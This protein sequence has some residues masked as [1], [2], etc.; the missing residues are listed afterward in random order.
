MTNEGHLRPELHFSPH[1]GWLNDP[2]GLIF[3]NGTWHLY[4]QHYPFDTV[5]GPM[6]WGH[7]VSR[8]LVHWEELSIALYPEGKLYRF[9][10]SMVYD[11]D[12]TSGMGRTAP[13]GSMIPPFAAF[14]TRHIETGHL[15]SQGVAFSYDGGV[16]FEDYPGN[17]VIVTP[18]AE[19][20]PLS[21]FRDPKVF[22]NPDTGLWNMTVAAKYRSNFYESRDLLH[23]T[24]TGSFAHGFREITNVWA[25]TDLIPFE[26]EEGRKWVL[27]A[28]MENKEGQ[29]EPRTMYFVGRF[30]GG[31]FTAEEKTEEPLWI[32]F[33]WDN[34]AGVT[35]NDC[36]FP[37]PVM[38][39]WAVNPRY[40][41]Q[42]PTGREGFRGH[43]TSAR[44][45]RLVKTTEGRRLS[46]RPVG[47]DAEQADLSDASNASISSPC[48][49]HIRG[50]AGTLSLANEQGEHFDVV[51]TK[52]EITIDRRFAGEQDFQADFGTEEYSR[53]SVRRLLPEGA[54]AD[55]DVDTTLILD[56][57]MIE[58]YADAGLETATVNTFP[59]IPYDL[60]KTDGDL[61]FSLYRLTK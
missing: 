45:L 33:G 1:R 41:N 48:L 3:H 22:K 54:S 25:C 43:M 38:I 49:L 27:F 52:D 56:G 4:F 17:P 16:T 20:G 12:N 19:G 14:Y 57:C 61:R 7:A 5:W 8:D 29:P 47:F 36:P 46:F 15:E 51:F 42:V 55:R 13:D 31:T 35:F 37:D 32:D 59:K 24:L 30:E 34:Y 26:T 39:S 10:G 40:A 28:S 53:R 58:V 2:N 21:D 11:R 9:S 18:P 6:H 23:W 60:A 44:R 50:T